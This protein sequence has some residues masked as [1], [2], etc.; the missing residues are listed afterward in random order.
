[1]K[2]ENG[3]KNNFYGVGQHELDLNVYQHHQSLKGCVWLIVLH[4]M[5]CVQLM[6]VFSLPV[7]SLCF[8]TKVCRKSGVENTETA[9]STDAIIAK[10]FTFSPPLPFQ[11]NAF[12]PRFKKAGVFRMT[13]GYHVYCMGSADGYYM[14]NTAILHLH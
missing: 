6:P 5:L 1:M 12:S 10:V 9:N 2:K 7:Q 8:I 13:F 11:W 3:K 4:V 14:S